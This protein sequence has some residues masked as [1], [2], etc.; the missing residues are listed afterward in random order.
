MNDPKTRTTVNIG[1]QEYALAGFESEEYIHRVA[2]QVDRKMNELQKQYPGLST[3]LLA[4]LTSINLADECIKAR[5]AQHE[6][7]EELAALR[8]EV[9]HLRI[10]CAL[11]RER[12]Q[13]VK[14]PSQQMNARLFDNIK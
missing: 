11:E 8:E 13:G 9:K 10:E 5:D 1:G 14:K 6:A 12:S 3:N 7:E 2:I 4:V